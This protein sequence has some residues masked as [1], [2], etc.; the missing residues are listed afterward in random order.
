MLCFLSLPKLPVVPTLDLLAIQN[1]WKNPNSFAAVNDERTLAVDVYTFKE[2][3]DGGHELLHLRGFKRHSFWERYLCFDNILCT[4]VSN[5]ECQGVDVFFSYHIYSY[6]L[7][8]E[9]TQTYEPTPMFDKVVAEIASRKWPRTA[10]LKA[11]SFWAT[12]AS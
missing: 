9:T 8:L 6:Y 4:N 12:E 1:R 10:A 2:T 3:V 11:Q 7:S 5:K